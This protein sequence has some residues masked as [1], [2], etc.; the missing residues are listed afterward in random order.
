MASQIEWDDLIRGPQHLDPGLAQ[1]SGDPPRGR[2]LALHAAERRRRYRHGRDPRR[3]RRGPCHQYRPAAADVRPRLAPTPPAFAHEALLV[4]SEGK[5]AK[6]LGSLGVEAMREAGIEPIALDRQAGADRHQPAGRAGRRPG[7]AD[8]ELRFRDLRPR[9]GALRHGRARPRSTPASSTS[10][11]FAAVADRLPAGMAEADW[12]AIRPNLRQRG[13]GRRLVGDPAR[14]CRAA[15]RA[16]EDRRLARR[17][18]AAAAGEID[19]GEAPWPQL[20]ARLKEASGRPGKALFQ[21]LRRALT[22]R[23]SGP[24]MAALLPLIGR[25]ESHR[26]PALRRRLTLLRS[27]PSA[28]FD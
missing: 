8:R 28:R 12:V 14:P 9:A 10:L 11:P 6:R 16:T 7:A 20:V 27:R 24:E 4:G 23:D 13:R 25:D 5:L 15:R 1:R 3:A 22:G 18:R 2:Q 19:W 26:P 17:R 21:P